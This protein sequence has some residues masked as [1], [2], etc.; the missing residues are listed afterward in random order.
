MSASTTA[1]RRRAYPIRPTHEAD[2]A[3]LSRFV[4][5]EADAPTR[6]RLVGSDGVE[7]EL[8]EEVYQVLAFVADEMRAGN[9]VSVIPH[10]QRISTQEA[11]ELLGIS[12]PTLIKLLERGEIPFETP[13][14]HRRLL[15]T[16]VLEYRERSHA[17][18]RAALDDLTAETSSLGLYE[19]DGAD[20]LDALKQAKADRPD[21][22]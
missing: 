2:I 5:S 4:E 15:L 20:Y 17:H 18:T 19:E 22:S 7:I 10:S 9:A 11:A 13:G 6:P 16:D 1:Q 8:P 12:R 14:R 3:R 21:P